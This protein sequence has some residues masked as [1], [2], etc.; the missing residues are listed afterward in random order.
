MKLV[1]TL[2]KEVADRDEGELVFEAVK[3]KLS[4]RPDIKITGHV[5]NHFIEA[6]PT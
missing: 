1:I 2:R 3:E 5:T 6:E 4:D